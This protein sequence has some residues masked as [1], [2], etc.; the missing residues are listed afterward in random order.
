MKKKLHKKIEEVIAPVRE[1]LHKDGGDLEIVN[2]RKDKTVEIRLLGS[3]KQCNMND[4]TFQ[5]GIKKTL[6]SGIPEIKEVVIVE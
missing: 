1:Y 4:F 6:L 2:I 5:Y 3:C